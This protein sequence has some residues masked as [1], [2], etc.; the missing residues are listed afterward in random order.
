MGTQDV[1]AA[2]IDFAVACWRE[3]GL[4]SVSAL[5]ARS[6]TSADALVSALRQFPGEGGVFGIVGVS[7]EFFIAI[8]QIGERT[9]ALISDGTAVL[10]W[11]LAE[12]MADLV[13]LQ[14]DEDDLEEFEP[15]GDLSL[16]SDFGLDSTE[17]SLLCGDED[18]YPDEQVRTIAKRVGFLPQ[19]SSV[20]PAG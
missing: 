1:D 13:G 19:L 16:F 9:K 20:I 6:T 8:H 7:D 5:P 17:M 12:E 14:V 3:E 4:W 15:I 11:D 18:L 10:D 2:S